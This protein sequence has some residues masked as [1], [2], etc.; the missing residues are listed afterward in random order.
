MNIMI[1]ERPL[2]GGG[3]GGGGGGGRYDWFNVIFPEQTRLTTLKR[4][5]KSNSVEENFPLWKNQNMKNP[6]IGISR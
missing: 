4:K 6:H 2:V 1:K 5:I 3:G